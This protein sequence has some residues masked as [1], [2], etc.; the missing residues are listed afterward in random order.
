MTG[1]PHSKHATGHHSVCLHARLNSEAEVRAAVLGLRSVLCDTVKG[2]VVCRPEQEPTGSLLFPHPWQ[3][4]QSA[5][6]QPGYHM[7]QKREVI[8]AKIIIFLLLLLFTLICCSTSLCSSVE[9]ALIEN[10][11]FYNPMVHSVGLWGRLSRLQ[12]I[13]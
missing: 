1:G 13:G 8:F 9:F 12:V 2:G 10:V 7:D 5:S 11:L 6:A 3:P 4:H